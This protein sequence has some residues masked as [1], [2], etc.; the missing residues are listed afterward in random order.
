MLKLSNILVLLQ[1]AKYTTYVD[2][3]SSFTNNLISDFIHKSNVSCFCILFA[4]A[5]ATGSMAPRMLT[6]SEDEVVPQGGDIRL[7]C[8]A[9]GSPPPTYRYIIILRG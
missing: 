7:V 8:C 5:D 1:L 9:V 2:Y 3:L 6:I 4:S